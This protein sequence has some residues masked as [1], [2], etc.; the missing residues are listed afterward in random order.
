[1]VYYTVVNIHNVRIYSG[2]NKVKPK[3]VF[4]KNPDSIFIKES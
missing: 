1:M 3:N 4:N 2:K